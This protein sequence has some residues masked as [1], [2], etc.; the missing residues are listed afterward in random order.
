MEQVVIIGSGPAGYTAAIY[1]A[2]ASLNPLLVEGP[3]PGGQL[4]TT[5]DVENF[6]G[7]PEAVSGAGLME[8]MREQCRRFGTKFVSGEV[9][10]VD[11]GGRPLKLFLEGGPIETKCVIIATGASAVY[12]GLESEKKLIGHG[13]S[14]CATCDGA[15]YRNKEVAVVGGGDTAMEDALFLTRFASKVYV[16]HRRDQFRASKIMGERVKQ[17]PKIE[18]I[19]DSVVTEVL[20]VSRMDVEA[21]SLKNVKTGE[22][23]RLAVKGLFVA[24]GHQPNTGPFKGQVELDEKGYIAAQNTRTNVPGVFAAGDVQDHVYRQAITAAGSGCMAA[25]EAERFLAKGTR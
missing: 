10:G 12:M 20:D 15:L 18:I 24:I 5:G 2:R 6:P 4:M 17:H 16:I 9:T 1:C 14:G 21:V 22:M 23:R 19:W 8:S 13:V 7:F 11:F 25:I 3:Q